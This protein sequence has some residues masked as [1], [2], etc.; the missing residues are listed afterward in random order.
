MTVDRRKF[1]HGAAATA[2]LAAG[3]SGFGASAWAAE[4]IK[5]ASIH[6]LSGGLDI[7]GKPMVD[8][9]TLAIEEA[10]A[11]GGLLGRKLELLSYDP[12]SN[13]QLYTQ[14]ATQAALKDKVAVVHGGITSASREV[15]RPVLDRFKTL[16]FYNTQYEGGVC[17]RNQFDTG[18][19]PAQTVE[20]L[21]PYSMKKW[22]KKVYVVAA[23]YNYGQITS[24]WVKKYVQENGGEVLSIDFFPLDVTNFGPTISKIQAAKP[25]CVW[26]ALVGGAHISFYR[27]WAAAGMR[28]QIPMA[29]TTFAVGNEHIVLSPEE[30][31]GMLVCYNYFEGLKNK[32]NEAF[33][34]RFHKRFGADYPNVTELA[35]G[36]YQGFWLWADAVKK[37]KSVDRLKVIEA[38]ETGISIDAPSGKV[39]IDPP[40]HHCI[41]DVHIAEVKD[42]KLVVLEDFPQQKPSDTAAVCNLI[43]NPTDNQQY[44]I[45]I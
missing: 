36:T 11:A 23:D 4:P 37:A 16:Y 29:S 13:M 20:K 22:G 38:L 26:S 34:G 30:C 31:N 17:D 7:Y 40:T 39:T 35:M 1:L 25:D 15:I 28:S 6:D 21:V 32:T 18:V 43:K 27:Q 9:L 3:G 2:A 45:K 41:L 42:K 44:V 12:Q 19:T 24:Q 5:V 10:N 14:F 8:A 33:I